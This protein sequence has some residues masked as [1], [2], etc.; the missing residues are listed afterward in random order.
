MVKAVI[1]Q[2]PVV[3]S[4]AMVQGLSKFKVLLSWAK[5]D[6]KWDR[7]MGHSTAGHPF[8]GPHGAMY[9]KNLSGC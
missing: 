3:P 9:I 7:A 5:D 8:Y 2:H 1:L 4:D 6:G